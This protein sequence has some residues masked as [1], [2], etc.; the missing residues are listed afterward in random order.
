MAEQSKENYSRIVA[1]VLAIIVI[2][3]AFLIVRP[4]IVALL[5]A[6]ALSYIF[7]PLYK[8]S[9]KKI[10]NETVSRKSLASGITCLIIILIVLVPTIIT[11]SVMTYEIRSGYRYIQENTSISGWGL[12][13]L[14]DNIIEM[15]GGPEQVK[16]LIGDITGQLFIWVQGIIRGIPNIILNI[17]VTVF[18]TYYFLKHGRDIYEFFKNIIPLPKERYKQIL[19]R[20]DNLSR[21]M[22]MG[23]VVVGVA[24]GILAW[25]GFSIFGVPNPVLWGFLTSIISIIPLLGAVMVWLPLDLYLFA[26]GYMTGNYYNAIALLFYGSLVVSTIDNLIKPKIVGDRSKIHPIVILLGIL[27]GIQLFGI[28]G[29]LIGPLILTLLDLVLEIYRESL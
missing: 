8:F 4:F 5:S 16:N 29:I 18:S 26:K 10:S 11:T 20:F 14:P 27:G 7:Y 3:L 22:I 21:G 24:Q 17:F 23:Q 15:I 9:L 13:A 28:P 6:A 1:M 25:A 2:V 19:E 12:P